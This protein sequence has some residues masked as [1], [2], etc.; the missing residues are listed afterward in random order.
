MRTKICLLLVFM[1]TLIFPLSSSVLAK[2]SRVTIIR[3]FDCGINEEDSGIPSLLITYNTWAVT[4]RNGNTVFHCNFPIPPELRPSHT[5]IHQGFL[6]STQSGL[7]TKSMTITTKTT[8]YLTCH[9]DPKSPYV[10]P[11]GGD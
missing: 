2:N 5:M 4:G 6:C 7:T 1:A 11:P 10:P 8:V 9:Y 3:G